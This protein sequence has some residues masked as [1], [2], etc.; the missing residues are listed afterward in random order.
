MGGVVRGGCIGWRRRRSGAGGRAGRY[1]GAAGI[2]LLWRAAWIGSRGRG[3]GYAR[4][5]VYF[6]RGGARRGRVVGLPASGG[7]GPYTAI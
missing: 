5:G 4:E 2:I 1:R 7:A 3:R 6:G